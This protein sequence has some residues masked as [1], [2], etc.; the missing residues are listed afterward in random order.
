MSEPL[1]S[2][3]A[4]DRVRALRHN[5]RPRRFLVHDPTEHGAALLPTVV[6]LHGAGG[7]AAWTLAETGWADKA[8]REGFL[9]VLPE[10]LRPDLAKPPHFLDNPSVWNDGSPPLVPAAPLA[11]D[12][13]FLDAVLDDVQKSFPVDPRRVYVTGFSNGGGMAFRLGA[14]RA[15]RYAALAPVAGHCW[16]ADPR[17]VRPVPTLYLVGSDDPLFPLAGG[18]IPSPWTGRRIHRP[19]L[20]DTLRRWA[21]ALGV[22]PEPAATREDDGVRTVVYHGPHATELTAHV[23]R[24]LGHHWPGGRG[25]FNPRIAGPASDRLRANDVIWE[26][27]QR[28]SLL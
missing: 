8:D 4:P 13:G 3:P 11:D 9:L 20:A 24:G 27:F 15:P 5:G 28:Q 22:P 7:T 26:F 16:L 2:R 6:M 18:E 21:V 1:P 25:Q 14:E 12:V 17:P 23:I 19:S 10:G